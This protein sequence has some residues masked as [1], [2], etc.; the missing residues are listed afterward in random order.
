M[1]RITVVASL[2]V[3]LGAAYIVNDATVSFENLLD[4]QPGQQQ[5]IQLAS[6]RLTSTDEAAAIVLEG[7]E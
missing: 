5:A 4:G 6:A 2:L 7:V 3:G 1:G